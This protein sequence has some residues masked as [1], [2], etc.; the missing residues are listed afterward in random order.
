VEQF[1]SLFQSQ[2]TIDIGVI[3]SLI[4]PSEAL[5]RRAAYEMQSPLSGI[6]GISP[7]GTVSV[8]SILMIVYAVLYV[9]V[10]ITLALRNFNRRDL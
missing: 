9:A 6:L 7:F 1:G 8:P 3:S 2:T 4:I 5:W 10:A